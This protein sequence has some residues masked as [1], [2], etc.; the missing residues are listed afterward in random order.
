[1]P[2]AQA[3]LPT[4]LIGLTLLASLPPA[5]TTPPADADAA[6]IRERIASIRTAILARQPEGI[7]HWGTPDWTFTGPDG[8]TVDR[9]AYLARARTLFTRIT[10]VDSLDTQVDRVAVHGDTADVEITQTMRRHEQGP[11][12]GAVSDVWIRY[13]ERHDWVRTADGWRVRRVAFLGTPERTSQ[14]CQC[15]PAQGAPPP[16]ASR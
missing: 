9:T 14:P 15:P 7:V 10:A 1:M 11:E 4:R 5:C 3:S 13:R 16:A 6:Q 2:Q 8:T 12:P